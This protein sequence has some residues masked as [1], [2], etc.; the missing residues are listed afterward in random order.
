[1]VL[2][3]HNATDEAVLDIIRGWIDVLAK[4]DYEAVV[5]ELGPGLDFAYGSYSSKAECLLAQIKRYVSSEYF[6]GVTDFIVTD[7]RLAK[8][9]NPEPRRHVTWYKPNNL[10]GVGLR[11]AIQFDLPL[12]GKWSDLT[13]DFVLWEHDIE[14]YVLALEEIS[15]VNQTLEPVLNF[16]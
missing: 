7:W 1:M 13:A 3:P 14:Y 16:S 6:P 8:G 5:A 2:I 9:G 12:N 4:E 10:G 11:G 15:S